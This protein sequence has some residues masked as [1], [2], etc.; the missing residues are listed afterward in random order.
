ME[1]EPPKKEFEPDPA[2]KVDP[3]KPVEASPGVP[4]KPVPSNWGANQ[5]HFL[6]GRPL[7]LG[8][9]PPRPRRAAP[10][11]ATPVASADDAAPDDIPPVSDDTNAHAQRP[12]GLIGAS[13]PGD[14]SATIP[15][16]RG[17]TSKRGQVTTGF[18][19]LA[20]PP[21]READVFSPASFAGGFSNQPIAQD[22]F[23]GTR[24]QQRPAAGGVINQPVGV[25][26]ADEPWVD[27]A[28]ETTEV[29]AG[30]K[31]RP[32][33]RATAPP[34]YPQASDLPNPPRRKRRWF[35]LRSLL[36]LMVLSMVLTAT[37]VYTLTPVTSTLAT[38]IHFDRFEG[39]DVESQKQ[40]LEKQQQTLNDPNTSE[41]ARSV[42]R[43]KFPAVS[44]GFLDEPRQMALVAYNVGWRP[45]PNNRAKG[46]L[47]LRVSDR[48]P[49][50]QALPKVAG[51]GTK[52]NAIEAD[53]ARLYSLAYALYRANGPAVESA[54]KLQT[55]TAALQTEYEKAKAR[56]DEMNAEI[57]RQRAALGN[58]SPGNLAD[59]QKQANALES[60]WTAAVAK[61]KQLQA[62]IDSLQ[63]TIPAN[64]QPAGTAQQPVVADDEMTKMESDLTQLEVQIAAT[65]DQLSQRVTDARESLKTA[66]AKFDAA[67]ND[68]QGAAKQDAGLKDYVTAGEE[69]QKQSR[70]LTDALVQRQEETTAQ[71]SELKQQMVSKIERIVL[72]RLRKIRS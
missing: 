53:R 10:F 11:S 14:I 42:L 58:D 1:L 68:A 26:S 21:V 55:D 9:T 15:P 8:P 3:P 28:G 33:G 34:G 25:P 63:K 45:G 16:F 13:D 43:D 37:G 20:M 12:S 23:G 57:E 30:R 7:Q 24:P 40:L 41:L 70:E 71:L 62:E 18:D 66:L 56:L 35:G 47:V 44:T 60:T 6:G 29:D 4:R 50:Y 17:G 54:A 36:I 65:R 67:I 72:T 31:P 19:G 49:G 5:D 38:V 2:A 59:Q 69:L 51:K 22:V 27:G 32:S 46:E 52:V 61:V 39:L 64:P 48:T